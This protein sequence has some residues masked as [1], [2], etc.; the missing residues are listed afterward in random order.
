L[1]ARFL[2]SLKDA[3]GRVTL[4]GFY[5]A[6]LPPDRPYVEPLNAGDASFLDTLFAR[7]SYSLRSGETCA[8][9][10][11]RLMFQPELNIASMR[12]GDT[13]CETRIVPARARAHLDINL[14]PG[15]EPDR[16]AESVRRQLSMHGLNPIH[17]L[18]IRAARPAYRC[19][20]DE[21]LALAAC[22]ALAEIHPNTPVIVLPSSASSGPV[23]GLPRAFGRPLVRVGTGYRGH[24]HTP[25]EAVRVEH[26]QS[27]VQTLL[28]LFRKAEMLGYG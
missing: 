14:V 22:A 15:Q 11:N 18:H 1:L 19:R 17:C 23:S 16:V 28:N 20:A 27:Y 6:V 26:Y 3:D 10:F 21:P 12:S 25:D 9:V 4:E 2:A 7:Y 5:E 24:A 13:G 8:D